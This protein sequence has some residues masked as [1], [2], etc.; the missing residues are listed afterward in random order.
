VDRLVQIAAKQKGMQNAVVDQT[1]AL[2][3]SWLEKN[4]KKAA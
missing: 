3:D 2:V 1:V 4:R